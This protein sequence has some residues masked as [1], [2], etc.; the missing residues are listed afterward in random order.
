MPQGRT[1]CNCKEVPFKIRECNYKLLHREKRE[2]SRSSPSFVKGGVKSFHVTPNPI[3]DICSNVSAKTDVFMNIVPV[4]AYNGHLEY[5]TYTHSWIRELQELV[6]ALELEGEDR[7]I[8]L[9]TVENEEKVIPTKLV[10]L[11]VTPA[12]TCG[13]RVDLPVVLAIDKL[14]VKPNKLPF[15]D[16]T[17]ISRYLV[18]IALR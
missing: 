13:P 7:S 14:P 1:Q 2:P 11:S 12:F 4:R 6:D 9:R 18:N 17:A 16:L 5:I 3:E 8:S 15:D 10:S